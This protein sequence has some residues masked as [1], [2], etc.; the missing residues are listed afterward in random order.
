PR[1]KMIDAP[2]YKF[3]THVP[4]CGGDG[5]IERVPGQAAYRCVLRGGAA[6]HKRKLY[7]FVSKKCFN[8]DGLGP[9]QIDAFLENNLIS[10]FDDIF[11]LEKGDM[12]TLPRFGEKSVDNLL[13]SIEKAR[14]VTLARFVFALSIDHVGEETAE[15]VAEHFKTIDSVMGASEEELKGLYGVGEV[16]AVSIAKWFAIEDNKSLVQRLLEQVDITAA[17]DAARAAA[18]TGA[19]AGPSAKARENVSGKTFVL[20][21]TLSGM[22]RD[23]AKVK[24]K[25]LGGDVSGTVSKK[26]DYVVAGEEAGSKLD[27]AEELGVKVLDEAAFLKLIG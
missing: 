23:E 19:A 17:S 12:M 18:Q 10:S 8:I 20:T 3:P 2:P 4:E 14:E 7:H 13:A 11:T 6:E 21:G 1:G 16:V 24:I 26:T 22:S 5:R 25:A 27:R 15:D 9:K